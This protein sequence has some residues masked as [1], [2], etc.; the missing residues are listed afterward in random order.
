M[1]WI[2]PIELTLRKLRFIAQTLQVLLMSMGKLLGGGLLGGDCGSRD[3]SLRRR[4]GLEKRL[5]D[6]PIYRIS[7]NVLADRDMLLLTETSCRDSGFRFCTEPPF[8]ARTLHSKPF[9]AAELR[10]REEP[11]A[12]CCDRKPHNCPGASVESVQRFRKQM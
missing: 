1:V 3:I 5:H 10:H 4:K 11:R 7:V 8:C 6:L 2:N 9:H 12:I